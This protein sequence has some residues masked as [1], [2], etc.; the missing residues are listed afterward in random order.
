MS[1]YTK[2]SITQMPFQALACPVHPSQ[3]WQIQKLHAMP[4]LCQCYAKK[5]NQNIS[6][7]H[8]QKSPVIK[9]V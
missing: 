1:Q 8:N 3:N 6:V 4:M 9:R 7:S 5:K 2:L